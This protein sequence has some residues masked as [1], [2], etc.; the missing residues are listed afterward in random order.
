MPTI[1]PASRRQVEAGSPAFPVSFDDPADAEL[2]WEWDDMHMPSALAPM[3]A[4]YAL[5]LGGGFNDRYRIF[6]FPQRIHCAIWNGYCYFALRFDGTEEELAEVE[7]RWVET[8]REQIETT[9]A[10]WRD[11]ALPRLLELYRSIA[12]VDVDGLAG[13]VLAEAWDAAWEATLEAWRIHFIAILGPYQVI[14]DLAD[15]YAEVVPDA[16]PGEAVRLTQGYGDELYEVEVAT[17]ALVA[18][19]E[20]APA[21]AACLREGVP[22]SPVDL[23]TLDGGAAFV[24]ALD[25]FL[26]RHGHLGQ[27]NE[28][29]MGPS[30]IEDPATFLAEFGKRI[31]RPSVRAAR[32]R[33]RLRAEADALADAF[34]ARVADRPHDLARFEHLL[35][36]ARDIGPLTEGHNYWIDRMAQSRLRHFTAR[37]G[38]RLSREGSI[39]APDDIFYLDRADVRAALVAP[40][41]LRAAV[42]E[43]KI[44]HALQGEIR[45]PRFVGREPTGPSEGD[46]FDGVRIE[47]KDPGVLR[48]TGGSAGIVRGPARVVMGAAEFDR[49]QAGDIVVCPSSNPSWVPIFAIAGGLVT[50]TGG[51]LAHAAVV[52]REY[53]LPAVVGTGDATT[54][55]ADGQTIEI[56][57]T[58]GTVRLL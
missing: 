39:E 1:P 31:G 23:A 36:H 42:A 40:H 54:R 26:A 24:A 51:V 27:A 41:D 53:G 48:G 5:T 2:T 25:S 57:G 50:D 55:I 38:R 52:A 28:D 4:E 9:A 19:A 37:V 20:A 46:R 45:P 29:F 10:W 13:P 7:R 47:S 32:R 15:L 56:D 33:E 18:A 49:V 16:P 8:K 34:R 17:E 43:R 6:G 30:W 44:A 14:D 58:L 12:A 35:R 22:V 21:V 3:A 11:E